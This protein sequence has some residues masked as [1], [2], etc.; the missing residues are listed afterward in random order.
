MFEINEEKVSVKI[1]GKAYTLRAPSAREHQEWSKKFSNPEGDP[2]ELFE[3]FFESI[4]LEKET[5]AKLT[6]TQ[7]GNLFQHVTGLKKS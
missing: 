2:V 1:M 7:L 3:Q 4:G 6:L 5:S